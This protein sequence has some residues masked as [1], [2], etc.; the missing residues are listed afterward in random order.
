MNQYQFLKQLNQIP[1]P[2]G[3][4]VRVQQGITPSALAVS[5]AT[6]QVTGSQDA[7]VIDAN[8]ESVIV[9]VVIPADYDNQADELKVAVYAKYVSGTSVTLD[10]DVVTLN[11]EGAAADDVTADLDED[12]SEV[13]IDAAADN[14]WAEFDLS[15]LGLQAGDVLSVEIDGQVT[16]V[17]IANIVGARVQYKSSI[18]FADS[19]AR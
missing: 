15:G 4:G 18:V 2:G 3:D 8:D 13:V 6:R 1:G 12:P 9:N 19:T 11:R 16:G 5:G 10:V 17:G 14:G 7:V